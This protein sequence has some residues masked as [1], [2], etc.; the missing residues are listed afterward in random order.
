MKVVRAV[1]IT[2]ETPGEDFPESPPAS[3]GAFSGFNV[4]FMGVDF[5]PLFCCA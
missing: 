5:Q 4:L 3:S 1:K 2:G